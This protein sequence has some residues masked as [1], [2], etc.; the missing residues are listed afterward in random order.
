MGPMHGSRKITR[1][2]FGQSIKRLIKTTLYLHVHVLSIL[3]VIVKKRSKGFCLT[4]N[5]LDHQNL[6]QTYKIQQTSL[7][8]KRYP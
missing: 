2:V 8:L 3:H 4:N 6:G 5:R 7:S 1:L